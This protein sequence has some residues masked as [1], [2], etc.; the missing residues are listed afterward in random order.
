MNLFKNDKNDKKFEILEKE[1]E[2]LSKRVLSLESIQS[3]LRKQINIKASDSEKEASQS[4]KKA[5][6][7]KNKAEQRLVE[8]E[9]ILTDIKSKLDSSEEILEAILNKNET[10]TE[11]I[12]MLETQEQQYNSTFNQ[13]VQKLDKLN[14]CLE[15]HPDLDEELEGVENNI[16]LIEENLKKSDAGLTI[17]NN[18]IKKI[19]TFYLSIFG[20]DYKDDNGVNARVE[21]KKDELDDTYEDLKKKLVTSDEEITKLSDRYKMSY[22]NFEIEHKESYRDIVKEI[23][24]LLPNALTAGLSAAFSKKKNDEVKSSTKLQNR[25]FVGIAILTIISIIPFWAGK[26]FLDQGIALEEVIYKIPR[27]V[28][29]IIPM[30]IPALWFTYSA[31][32]KLNLS[33]RL[34]EEYAHKE[35]LS[36]TY[37]GLSKQ[38]SNLENDEQ[39]IEL[40]YRLLSNFLQVTSENPGKLISNYQTS[41]HPI[42]EAL[43]QSY[44]FQLTVDKLKG[45][46]GLGSVAAFFNTK[47]KKSIREKEEVV[48]R[49]FDLKK[50]EI[51]N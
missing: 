23:E 42:M 7:Y 21:G 37:E 26:Q 13:I 36:K 16:S 2:K 18:N 30:Y 45:I 28:L 50:E 48:E 43:E 19:D 6:E 44:K 32:K 5:A 47:S 33:K 22:Q 20:Y 4:S 38:I 10:A 27:L 14:L 39:T 51:Q 8:S 1:N 35:V 11:S 31:N 49:S 41:D 25:F 29:A 9:Q 15:K 46:P 40:K 3:D 24:S 12:K 17:I 34:I